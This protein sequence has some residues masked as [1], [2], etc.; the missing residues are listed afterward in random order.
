MASAAHTHASAGGRTRPTDIQ[1]A[2]DARGRCS[3]LSVTC[4]EGGGHEAALGLDSWRSCAPECPAALLTVPHRH[5][6]LQTQGCTRRYGTIVFPCSSLLDGRRDRGGGATVCTCTG[7]A[8]VRIMPTLT[9]QRKGA[10]RSHAHVPGGPFGAF[11][12]ASPF[13]CSGDWKIRGGISVRS[14]P[15]C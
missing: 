13:W 8:I 2:K 15:T 10:P 6:L 3:P 9:T 12:V 1:S 11:V 7:T 14:S 5:H 4:I